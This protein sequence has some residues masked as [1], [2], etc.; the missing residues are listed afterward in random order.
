M[1]TNVM[2]ERDSDYIWDLFAGQTARF[3]VS[4]WKLDQDNRAD[5]Y[6]VYVEY[7]K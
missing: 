7:R 3:E 4:S 2:I 6:E 1:Q 5:H